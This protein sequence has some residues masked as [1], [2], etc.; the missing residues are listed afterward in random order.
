[1][2]FEQLRH[3][4][5]DLL[6]AYQH[7]LDNAGHVILDTTE[8]F[9]EFYPDEEYMEY[10]RTLYSHTSSVSHLM[11]ETNELMQVVVNT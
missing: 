9:S 4:T 11:R 10:A 8:L 3:L 5:L 6:S 7:T 1:M 2:P